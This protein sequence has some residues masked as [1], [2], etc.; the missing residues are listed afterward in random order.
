[1][2]LKAR[3]I[4]EIKATALRFMSSSSSFIG[5]PGRAHRFIPRR[6]LDLSLSFIIPNQRAGAR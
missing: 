4:L 3:N 6:R 5:R 2:N 1:M